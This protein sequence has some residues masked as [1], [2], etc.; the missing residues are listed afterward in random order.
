[1]NAHVIAYLVFGLSLV[2]LFG[3][4]IKFYYAKKRKG[5]VEDAKYKMLEDDDS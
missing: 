2:V 3:V 5:K 1:M 4:I